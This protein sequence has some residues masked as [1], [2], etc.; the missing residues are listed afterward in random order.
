METKNTLL[1]KTS[2]NKLLPYAV[3][4]GL[5]INLLEVRGFIN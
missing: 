4:S 5:L 3:L 1:E 2:Y